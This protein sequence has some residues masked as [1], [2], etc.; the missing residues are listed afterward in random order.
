MFL[1][2]EILVSSEVFQRQFICNLDKCKGACC[3]EGD[4]GAPLQESE[5]VK[6]EQ[7]IPIV[8]ERLP[9]ESQEILSQKGGYEYSKK[10]GGWVT[11]LRK[12]G[13]C[14][15]LTQDDKGIAKCSIE[16]AYKEGKTEYYK[17]I[18]CHLYPI[19]VTKNE[20]TGF[21]CL[22]YDEW[23]ICSAACALGEEHEMPVFRFLR[24]AIVREYGEDFYEE[25]DGVYEQLVKG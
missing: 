6:I 10:Y 23:D 16:Q 4:F 21:E 24:E 1:I 15:F 13:A 14:V 25:I 22:N 20:D 3:W 5:K 8:A 7:V 18:S 2:Q 9:E 12:S 11:T 17:P 19:R